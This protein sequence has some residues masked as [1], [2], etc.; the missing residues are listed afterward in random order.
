MSTAA[1]LEAWSKGRSDEA[2]GILKAM[3]PAAADDALALQLW[4]LAVGKSA[5]ADAAALLERAVR[6]APGDS[7]AHYNLAVTL[8]DHG[9]FPRAIAHYNQTLRADPRHLGALNNL[10]DLLRRRGRPQEG[11]ALLERYRAGGGEVRGLE[12]RFAKMAM[13]LRSFDDAAVWFEAAERHKPGDASVAWEHAMLSLVREDFARGWPRYERRL[14][15]HGPRGL[16]IHP[17]EIL[18]WAGESVADRRLLL[19]REQGLGDMIMFAQA[20]GELVDEGARLHLALH[21]PL[22][23]L[24]AG[25][26][27]KAR[28]WSSIT[29]VGAQAEPAQ[30]WL[31]AAGPIDLQAPV[32]SLGALRRS[33]GFSAPRA[34]LRADERLAKVWA[35]RLDA[36]CR[37]GLRRIGL[38]LGSRQAGWSD[39]GRTMAMR[40]SIPPAR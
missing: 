12:I 27:P 24:M 4:A 40:K 19:H 2:L 14:E 26:F 3:G 17:Y 29:A 10:S 18:P 16:G 7:Q 20:F 31:A 1:A 36:L 5:P 11:W 22:V 21:P 23:R 37:P 28:V 33:R 38:A 30:T 15:T 25:N 13:D 39:D 35:E 6:I 9:D 8:Q 34:Y 32:C